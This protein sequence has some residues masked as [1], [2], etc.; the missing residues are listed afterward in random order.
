MAEHKLTQSYP[1]AIT[2]GF[3]LILGAIVSA[4]WATIP[5]QTV[6][7]I[8]SVAG[9]VF[10]A[11]AGLVAHSRVT[12]LAGGWAA[13][14][15]EVVLTALQDAVSQV[16]N[17]ATAPD[18]APAS[19][20]AAAAG[21]PAVP[22]AARYTPPPTTPTAAPAGQWVWT[23]ETWSWATYE[24]KN[25]PPPNSGQGGSRPDP[26]R[27]QRPGPTLPQPGA[28]LPGPPPPRPRD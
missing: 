2:T 21:T 18:P 11:L 28:P 15:R 10:G 9:V 22:A 26:A 7:V 23:G 8:T 14:V 16:L 4:G 1:V 19:D 12:P 6:N 13:Q 25:V 3:Q 5:D 20:T 17:T 24:P 27:A